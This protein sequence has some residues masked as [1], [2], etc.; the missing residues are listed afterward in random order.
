MTGVIYARFSSDNQREESIEGQVR[1]CKEYADKTGITIVRTYIDRA[2]SGTTDKR[3]DFQ[4]MI[5]DSYKKPIDVVLVWKFDRF[6]RSRNDSV[7]YKTIL[8]KNN[9]KVTSVTENISDDPTGIIL[10][11]MLEGINE[12][13]SAELSVKVKRGMKENALK[14][15]SNGGRIPYGLIINKDRKYEPDKVK[16]AVVVDIFKK[17][18]S[19]MTIKQIADYLSQNNIMYSNGK[20]FSINNISYML[21]NRRYIGDYIYKDMITENAI[22]PI[23]DKQLFDSVQEKL[24]KNAKAPARYKAEDVYILTS[25]LFCGKCG[26]YMVGE[27]GTS[28]NG[29]VYRYYKCV[30]TKKVH[31]CNKKNVKKEWIEDIVI[32][33]TLELL[34]DESL[35]DKLADK[36]V[37]YINKE[38]TKLSVLSD[39]IKEV[40]HKIKNIVDAV[41][42]GIYTKATNSRL[43]ELEN[44]EEKLNESIQIEKDNNIPITKE[45]ILYWFESFKGIDST[46]LSN[47]QFLVDTFINSIFLYDDKITITY[48]IDNKVEQLSLEDISGSDKKTVGEPY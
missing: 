14:C 8:K 24:K 29:M 25:K 5:E 22:T 9:V 19:G 43:T 3:P 38:N 13:Y 30:G 37:S 36:M 45:H 27:S 2:I 16:A 39:Q 6:S 31:T 34:S 32:N 11:S 48:N 1:E 23:V 40:K 21:K 15:T 17:Y 46:T 28:R 33:K 41:E 20:N 44:E 42:Q 12:Y 4:R 18:D 35:L 10:E 26:K 47:R 7:K